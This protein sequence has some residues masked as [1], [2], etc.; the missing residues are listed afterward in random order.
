MKRRALAARQEPGEFLANTAVF[1][2]L[3]RSEAF[4]QVFGGWLD[5]LWS[6]GTRATLQRYLDSGN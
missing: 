2:D 6:D 4:A 3:G 5:R 1:G